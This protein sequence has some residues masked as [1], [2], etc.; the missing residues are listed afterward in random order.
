MDIE[1]V[2]DVVNL[3]AMIF[4]IYEDWSLQIEA[5]FRYNNMIIFLVYVSYWFM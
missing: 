4:E 1:D 3:T 2:F 5:Y